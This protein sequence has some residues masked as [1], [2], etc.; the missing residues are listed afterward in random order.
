MKSVASH[1]NGILKPCPMAGQGVHQWLYG[2]SCTLLRYGYRTN[3]IAAI[4]VESSG[5]CGRAVTAYEIENTLSGAIQA[6]K[7]GAAFG[8]GLTSDFH[9]RTVSQTHPKWPSPNRRLM[10]KA[11]AESDKDIDSLPKEFISEIQSQK[12]A[13]PKRIIE[14][15]FARD[16]FVCIGQERWKFDTWTR[17]EAISHAVGSQYI[18][19]NPF[20]ARR[21][22]KANGEESAKGNALVRTRRFIIVEFDFRGETPLGEKLKRQC[23]LHWRLSHLYPLGLLVYSGNDSL[24]GWY[25][26][27]GRSEEANRKFFAR[28]CMLGADS[29]L[30]CP[31]QFTRTPGGRHKNG[32][33]QSILYFNPERLSLL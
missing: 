31:S 27:R 24:H 19:P 13:S 22:T 5:G 11:F 8:A 15:A 25:A 14:C 28:A 18:V 3:Q 12:V 1:P 30:W 33:R 7:G 6:V 26:T 20:K 32:R 23:Q 2:A 16:D 21:W 10:A 17:A 9:I 4:L 29:K